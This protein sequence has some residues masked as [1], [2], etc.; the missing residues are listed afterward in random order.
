MFA[1]L[2]IIGPILDA[3]L[4]PVFNWLMKKE[5]TKVETIH[6]QTIDNQTAASVTTA[7]KDDV[8][9]QVVRDLIMFPVGVWTALIVWD[10]IVAIKYPDY[11]WGVLPLDA[12]TGL[13]FLPYAVM[14][15]LFGMALI[16]R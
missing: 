9:S 10:K 7:F 5:D 6:A 4:K 16:K 12:G 11:V 8:G 14:T 15:F 3:I 1:F 2:P 13:S